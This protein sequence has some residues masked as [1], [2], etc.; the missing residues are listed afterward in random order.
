MAPPQGR[1]AVYRLFDIDGRLL[2]VGISNNP[3]ARWRSHAHTKPWWGDVVTR[4]IEWHPT[5]EGAEQAET[6]LVGALRPKWNTAPGMPRRGLP[7]IAHRRIRRGWTPPQSLLDLI[8]RYE[9]EQ[10]TA[11]CTRDEIEAEIVAVMATSVSASRLAKFLPWEEPTI[12]AIG[13]RG[14]VPKLRRATV[15]SVKRAAS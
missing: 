7:A 15:V 1:T 13:E 12:R 5:R 9:D 4:E 8:A 3:H 6:H 14:G 11:G 10:R 2:Y